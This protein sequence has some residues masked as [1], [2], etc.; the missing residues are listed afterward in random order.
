MDNYNGNGTNGNG[1]G[2]SGN[3]GNGYSRPQLQN[4]NNVMRTPA[5]L[6]NEDVGINV[7]DYLRALARGKWVV[8]IIFIIAVVITAFVSYSQQDVYEASTSIIIRNNKSQTAI[9]NIDFSEQQRTTGNEIA[10]LR[11]RTLSERIA[12]KLTQIVYKDP[13][14]KR[15]TLAIIKGGGN[16]FASYAEIGA[17]V[18]GGLTITGAKDSDLMMIGFRSNSAEEAAIV[19][20]AIVDTYKDYNKSTT[21]EA[22]ERLMKFLEGQLNQK[23]D[24]LSASEEKLQRY[25]EVN[26]V[27]SIDEEANRIIERQSNFLSRA[28]ESQVQLGALQSSLKSYTDELKA[29]APKVST[30][31]IQSSID[32][33]M[34]TLNLKIAEKEVQR[35]GYRSDKTGNPEV[36]SNIRI[37][38]EQIENL[39]KQ[40][41]QRIDLQ[42]KAGYGNM[43]IPETYREVGRKKIAAELEVVRSEV[44]SKLYRD[45][46]GKYEVAFQKIPS[47]NIEYLRLQRNKASVEGLY[48]LLEKRYQ[49]SLIA[50]QQLPSGTQIIDYAITPPA[51]VAPNRT[52]NMMFG[53]LAGLV[54]GVGAVVLIQLSDRTVH[55]PE[56]AERLG[57][58]LLAT[59]PVIETFDE[60]V[61][62]KS[63]AS[64]KV[65]EG[66]DAEYKKIAS[67]LVTHF[68]PKSAVSEAYR[69]LRTNLL[70]STAVRT[71][72]SGEQLGRCYVVSSS[73]PKEGKSTTASNLA[74]TLAQGGNKVLLI[75]TDLRRPIIHAIFGFNK[76]PGMTNYLVGRAKA[77]DVIRTSLTAN[78]DIITSGTIPPNPSEL[79]STPRM[80]EFIMEMR[81]R[82]DV[83]L[84]DSP[85]VI[86]VT[87]AQIL[88]KITDGSILVI[89]SG[90]TQI[91]LAKRSR[92]AIMKVDGKILGMVLNN[93]DVSNSYGSYY[94]YYRYYNYYYDSKSNLTRKRTLIDYVTDRLMGIK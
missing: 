38:N 31:A 57:V 7:A 8:V 60:G 86:A 28:E 71:D 32:P 64:V 76:E 14:T 5:Q 52:R 50:Q 33:Y 55:T 45:L 4:P 85:P 87:D 36:E 74:I 42:I 22:A 75:D 62:D 25:M 44:A 90:Q 67:H 17:R 2:M 88:A 89:S 65:V 46:A 12:A 81:R 79:I 24:L 70:F 23:R 77:D 41:Q 69:T 18:L 78:L 35:D 9:F 56:Q 37:L 63:G 93:F 61:R 13:L 26:G 58:T 16:G 82:Y 48:L 51:P 3:G 80:K 34:K 59:I 84:F 66:P 27:V 47:R 6:M 30:A 19:S 10:I 49:E 11:S 91:E 20:R 1:G 73:A 29:L 72:E 39:Q 83:V 68:E 94:K 21:E 92:D 54:L 15:D 53:V 40:L 43:D